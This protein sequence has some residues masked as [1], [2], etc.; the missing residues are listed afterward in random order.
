[1]VGASVAP[2][3][4]RISRVRLGDAWKLF[5]DSGHKLCEVPEGSR[6]DCF[7]WSGTDP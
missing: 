6:A 1:M 7:L 3:T 4:A 2:F 5:R